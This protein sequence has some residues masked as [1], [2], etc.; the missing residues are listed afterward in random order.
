MLSRCLQNAVIP[1]TRYS[2][3]THASGGDDSRT[4]IA[5]NPRSPAQSHL[6]HRARYRLDPAR[7]RGAASPDRHPHASPCPGPGRDCPTPSSRAG[8]PELGEPR[9]VRGP[10]LTIRK[11]RT[12]GETRRGSAGGRMLPRRLRRRRRRPA[13]W[14]CP[15]LPGPAGPADTDAAD[16]ASWRRGSRSAAPRPERPPQV[17][18]GGRGWAG[19]ASGRGG[20]RAASE[21]Q[22]A[23]ARQEASAP[24][25][26]LR[27]RSSAAARRPP[28]SARRAPSRPEAAAAELPSRTRGVPPPPWPGCSARSSSSAA[29]RPWWGPPSTPSTSGRCCCPR[30][31]VSARSR[32]G[33]RAGPA[34][35]R[36]LCKIDV[37]LGV[38]WS[39]G[40]PALLAATGLCVTYGRSVKR[41]TG[42]PWD[43]PVAARSGSRASA[44]A[45]PGR[46]ACGCDAPHRP[47]TFVRANEALPQRCTRLL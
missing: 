39:Q 24:A 36:G 32:A 20:G 33:E 22:S 46:G 29:S 47:F 15:L 26:S 12:R 27:L 42:K 28:R 40:D 13:A 31:T 3:H 35:L 5:S 23:G 16:P 6:P 2:G 7:P 44:P 43:A 30:S 9:Q 25:P 1:F 11:R 45:K 37:K 41:R 38:V 8:P 34:G 18:R 4:P 19:A 17:R 14:R 10:P 21:R